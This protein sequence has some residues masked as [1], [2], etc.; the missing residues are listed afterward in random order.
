MSDATLLAS[1]R[2]LFYRI[3]RRQ[4]I[5]ISSGVAIYVCRVLPP[6]N[7]P[8]PVFL[9]LLFLSLAADSLIT[10]L[11]IQSVHKGCPHSPVAETW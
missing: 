6:P 9:F 2:N 10:H 1:Y 4:N 5:I 7:P 3:S 8:F 11:N